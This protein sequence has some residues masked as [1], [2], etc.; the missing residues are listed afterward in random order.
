VT[1]FRFPAAPLTA[2]RLTAFRDRDHVTTFRGRLPRHVTALRFAG[3]LR[4]PGGPTTA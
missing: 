3:G 1:T 2:F 4:L